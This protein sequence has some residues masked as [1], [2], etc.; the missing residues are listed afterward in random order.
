MAAKQHNLF[1]PGSSLQV[2][3]ALTRNRSAWGS[4]AGPNVGGRALV[5]NIL[6]LGSVCNVAP[7]QVNKG[8]S[9]S[10]LLHSDLFPAEGANSDTGMSVCLPWMQ[11]AG[12]LVSFFVAG[13]NV[14]ELFCP[15]IRL[16]VLCVPLPA[17]GMVCCGAT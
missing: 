7:T 17:C 6:R 11:I 5:I 13:G 1:V 3:G 4:L 12:S 2:C 16:R 14:L 15:L 9:G 10:S 8:T